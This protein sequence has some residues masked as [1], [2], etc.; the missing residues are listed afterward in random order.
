MNF[1]FRTINIKLNHLLIGIMHKKI[2]KNT[3]FGVRVTHLKAFFL[4]RIINK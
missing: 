3:S 4:N 2:L 1:V